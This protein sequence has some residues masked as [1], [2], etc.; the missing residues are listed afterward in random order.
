MFLATCKG[1][2]SADDDDCGAVTHKGALGSHKLKVNDTHAWHDVPGTVKA[3]H[4]NAQSTVEFRYSTNLA[5]FGRPTLDAFTWKR[6]TAIA[7]GLVG[8]GCIGAV[9]VAVEEIAGE[10]YGDNDRL[11]AMVA[12]AVDAENNS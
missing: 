12:N 5:Q 1:V 10:V 7:V 4:L 2:A 6:W 8:V 3:F 11:S 9:V